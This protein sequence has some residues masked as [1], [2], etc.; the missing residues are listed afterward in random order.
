VSA[1]ATG[2]T[3][4]RRVRY[5][6]GSARPAS[7]GIAKVVSLMLVA[8]CVATVPLF[9]G[10]V[11]DGARRQELLAIHSRILRSAEIAIAPAMQDSDAPHGV[12]ADEH[13]VLIRNSSLRD[14][15]ALAYGVQSWQVN[16]GPWLDSTRYDVRAVANAPVR[17]PDELQPFALRG[18]VAKL[19]ASRFGLQIHV[20]QRCQSPCGKDDL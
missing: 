11:T 20:N 15:I 1:A 12:I 5:I 18:L 14:L 4:T 2:G 3:L 7:P 16:G 19:L 13:G 8:L 9:A 6:L 17:N 10:A